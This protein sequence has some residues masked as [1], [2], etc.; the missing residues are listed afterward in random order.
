MRGQRAKDGPS[1]YPSQ[2][3]LLITHNPSPLFQTKLQE[4]TGSN[5]SVRSTH[6]P[7]RITHHHKLLAIPN[8]G[9]YDLYL[10]NP[11]YDLMTSLLGG[12]G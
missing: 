11:I 12:G 6:Y 2:H 9:R 7:S 4:K 10:E 5:A 3:P 1:P 8:V